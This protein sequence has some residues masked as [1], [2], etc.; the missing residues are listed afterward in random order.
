[1]R[2]LQVMM[3]DKVGPEK[4]I[5]ETDLPKGYNGKILMVVIMGGG[6]DKIVC[7]RSGDLW[8]R[9]IL[10]NTQKEIKDLGF[11]KSAAYE[12]GGAC[13]RF[14]P[15]GDIIIHGTSDDYGSC[16]KNLAAEFIKKK[17]PGKKIIVLD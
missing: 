17:F 4:M 9:E 2:D 8:H 16:D 7:L 14:E 1:M 10:R 6:I 15:N 13:V 12:L 11:S 3:D 5:I